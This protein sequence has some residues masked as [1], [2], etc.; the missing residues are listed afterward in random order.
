MNTKTKAKA[1]KAPAAATATAPVVPLGAKLLYTVREACGL[2][3]CSQSR[4]YVKL[5]KGEIESVKDGRS[6]RIP[7][8]AVKAYVAQLR[9]QNPAAA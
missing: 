4:L 2:I 7:A 1:K 8:D 9:G 6:R 5:A 3:G